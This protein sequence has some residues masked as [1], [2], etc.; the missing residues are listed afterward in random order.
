MLSDRSAGVLTGHMIHAGLAGRASRAPGPDRTAVATQCRHA[1][2][3]NE[4]LS[5]ASCRWMQARS[6]PQSIAQGKTPCDLLQY[7]ARKLRRRPGCWHSSSKEHREP[8]VCDI[9]SRLCVVTRQGP[10][11][12]MQRKGNSIVSVVSHACL[13]LAHKEQAVHSLHHQ[14]MRCISPHELKRG[15]HRLHHQSRRCRFPCKPHLEVARGCDA[16]EGSQNGAAAPRGPH[17]GGRG[18]DHCAGC[19]GVGSIHPPAHKLQLPGSGCRQT[20][21]SQLLHSGQR[22]DACPAQS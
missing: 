13:C 1:D 6:A 12:H 9:L 15:W 19:A 20:D 5:V 16:C 11:T 4:P 3:P 2:L 8:S 22:S 10:G 14:R 17:I 18:R 21:T 7:T